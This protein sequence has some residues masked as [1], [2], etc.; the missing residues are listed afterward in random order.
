MNNGFDVNGLN[1]IGW[2]PLHYAAMFNNVNVYNLLISHGADISAV[3]N[4]KF[5]N[6]N[7][8]DHNSVRNI[9]IYFKSKDVLDLIDE[10]SD[11]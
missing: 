11:Y 3:T 8:K 9:A 6:W 1:C 5:S 4:K 10:G 7:M 2:T